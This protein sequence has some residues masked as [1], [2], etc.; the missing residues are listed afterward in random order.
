[1]TDM[2]GD[3]GVPEP[4]DQEVQE[5]GDQP[6]MEPLERPGEEWIAELLKEQA[7]ERAEAESALGGDDSAESGDPD[8]GDSDSGD[9]E[10]PDEVVEEVEAAVVSETPVV[11]EHIGGRLRKTV[12]SRRGALVGR[13]SSARMG[14]RDPAFAGVRTVVLVVAVALSLTAIAALVQR[15]Q[16]KP[17]EYGTTTEPIGSTVLL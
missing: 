10:S 6:D 15:P 8:T 17:S 3:E 4:V 13:G 7:E 1:M 9:P 2:N 14:R 12:L 16:P 5:S 11:P